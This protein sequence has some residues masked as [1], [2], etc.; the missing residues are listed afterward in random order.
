MPDADIVYSDVK[1]KRSK[2]AGRGESGKSSP[3]NPDQKCGFYHWLHLKKEKKRKPFGSYKG[4]NNGKPQGWFTF[5]SFCGVCFRS[6]FLSWRFHNI[7]WCEILQSVHAAA[8]WVNLQ[9]FLKQTP[10][11]GEN[12]LLEVPSLVFDSKCETET[13]TVLSI[14]CFHLLRLHGLEWRSRHQGHTTNNHSR[15]RSH[16]YVKKMHLL[17]VWKCLGGTVWAVTPVCP[18]DGWDWFQTVFLFF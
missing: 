9:Y 11:Q 15:S 8:Q 10:D 6:H 3:W 1:F 16:S 4:Q 12:N 17:K 5:I 13:D 7:F 2:D 14:D 18:D